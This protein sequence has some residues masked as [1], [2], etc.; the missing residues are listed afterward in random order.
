MP[1]GRS[2]REELAEDSMSQRGCRCIGTRQQL[3]H[4]DP[5]ARPIVDGQP[6]AGVTHIQY[7][8]LPLYVGL[9]SPHGRRGR[10]VWVPTVG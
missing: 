3:A 7:S 5:Q 10:L 9:Q 4:R 6:L 8:T 1:A 2:I